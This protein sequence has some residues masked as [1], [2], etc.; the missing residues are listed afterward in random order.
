MRSAYPE[1]RRSPTVLTRWDSS[2]YQALAT[3]PFPGASPT[4]WKMKREAMASRLKV[5]NS[6]AGNHA[7]AVV[8]RGWTTLLVPAMTAR[9]SGLQSCRRPRGVPEPRCARHERRAVVIQ[10]QPNPLS[11]A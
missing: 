5:R 10:A 7:A 9:T 2:S 6:R 4:A 1:G 11:L 8:A 3:G